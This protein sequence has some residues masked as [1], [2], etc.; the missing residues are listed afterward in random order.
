MLWG[1]KEESLEEKRGPQEGDIHWAENKI[2]PQVISVELHRMSGE[3]CLEEEKEVP[4]EE[5]SRS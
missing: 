5:S 3:G 4:V 2:S 1:R